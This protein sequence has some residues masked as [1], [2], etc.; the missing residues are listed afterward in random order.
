MEEVVIT[1]F[2]AGIIFLVGSFFVQEKLTQKDIDQISKLSDK[3]LKIII[4]KKLENARA[5]IEETIDATIEESKEITVREMEKATNEKI[6]AIS[7]FSDTIVDTMN[8]THNEIMFLYSMLNDKQKDITDLTG[9]L[10]RITEQI[11]SGKYSQQV[12]PKPVGQPVPTQYMSGVQET[13]QQ[14]Q[15]VMA[16]ETFSRNTQQVN[17]VTETVAVKPVRTASD[18]SPVFNNQIP[19]GSALSKEGLYPSNK[20]T[21]IL[22]LHKEGKSDVAIAKELH[23]GL[24]EVKL[25]LGLYKG[26][27]NSEI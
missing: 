19:A 10:Q 24:G 18:M 20:N 8:Q 21:E 25:V 22:K 6:M 7:E 3:E 14:A 11:R 27:N 9:T 12:Q 15:P 2:I 16:T 23:C 17:T 13:A 4:G 1:L 5:E 26:D